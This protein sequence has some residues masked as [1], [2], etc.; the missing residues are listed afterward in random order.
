MVG[1]KGSGMTALAELFKHMGAL[2]QGSDTHERFYTDAIL[3]ELEI[4]VIE[5]FNKA[6]LPSRCDLVVYSAAYDPAVH[7]ELIAASERGLPM[8]TYPEALGEL[9]RR[10]PS[11][12]IS[13]VHGKTTTTAMAGELI[14]LGGLPGNVLVGSASIGFGGQGSEYPAFHGRAVESAAW[15]VRGSGCAGC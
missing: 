8:L 6:N 10:V 13:G 3:T 1:I 12:G 15:P 2:P 4:P 9:S 7:P 11:V 5:G 14:R